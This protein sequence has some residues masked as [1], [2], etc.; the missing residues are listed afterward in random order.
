MNIRKPLNLEVK[1]VCKKVYP[2]TF[3]RSA[4][5]VKCIKKILN[6]VEWFYLNGSYIRIFNH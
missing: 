4:S 2:Y 6:R 1:I 5:N 3:S